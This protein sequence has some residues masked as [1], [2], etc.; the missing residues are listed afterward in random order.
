MVGLFSSRWCIRP[1][2]VA[3]CDYR[4]GGQVL[5]AIFGLGGLTV[6]ARKACVGATV[7]ATTDTSLV[8]EKNVYK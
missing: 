7:V 8:N 3:A 1:V 6:L 5:M 4:Y 2:I